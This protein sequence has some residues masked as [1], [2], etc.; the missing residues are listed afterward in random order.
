MRFEF[1]TATRIIFGAGTLREVGP[2]AREF[3]PRAL[4]VAGASTSLA[5][6]PGAPAPA[7]PANRLEKLAAD[8][9]KAI[10]AYRATL[11]PVLRLSPP[12][13]KIGSTNLTNI[14]LLR[15]IGQT[16]LPVLLSTGLGT[17]GPLEASAVDG[18]AS[19]MGQ[20]LGWSEDEKKRQAASIGWRYEALGRA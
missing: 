11:E 19:L 9:A 17:L 20:M 1:A 7:G 10:A 14:P 4:V 8:S 2:L 18:V 16:G 6:S 15:A 12:I 13:L 3:A 5:Q